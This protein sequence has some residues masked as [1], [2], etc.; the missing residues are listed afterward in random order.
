MGG[1]AL[2]PLPSLLGILVIIILGLVLFWG[3]WKLRNCMRRA[4]IGLSVLGLV[5]VV[6]G[7]VS[8]EL[9]QVI[10]GEQAL[11]LAQILQFVLTGRL[12]LHP[13]AGRA[14]GGS[15]HEGHPQS[16]SRDAGR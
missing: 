1:G 4:A 7:A 16:Q 6:P 9:V 13:T 10:G 11:S 2:T 15:A 12:E 3:L 14:V 8:E 5:Y